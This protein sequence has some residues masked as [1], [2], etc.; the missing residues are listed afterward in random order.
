[1]SRLFLLCFFV[2][3][4]NRHVNAYS[5][6]PPVQVCT[7]MQPSPTAH[8][9]AQTSESPYMIQVN[10]SY[11]N[12]DGNDTIK[13]YVKA[14]GGRKIAGFLI[15]AREKGKNVPLGSFTE[16]PQKAK[17]LDCTSNAYNAETAVGMKYL[18]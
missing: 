18:H 3:L 4:L 5:A 14:S 13:V 11:Y 9:D 8:G 17:Y 12:Y 6:G 2:P 16:I 1:M 10:E 7:S 15:Q